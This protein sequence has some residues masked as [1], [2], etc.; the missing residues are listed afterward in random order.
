M[1]GSAGCLPELT[2]SDVAL[3]STRFASWFPHYRRFS[4]KATVIDVLEVQPDFLQWLAEDGLVLPLDSDDRPVGSAIVSEIED[5]S[6]VDGEDDEEEE[7]EAN[8]YLY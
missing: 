6:R 3:Q 5:G 4:P 1:P 2:P 7:E 8:A